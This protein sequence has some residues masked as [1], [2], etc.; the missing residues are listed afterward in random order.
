M[1][2]KQQYTKSPNHRPSAK[3]KPPESNNGSALKPRREEQLP[4][5]QN[6]LEIKKEERGIRTAQYFAKTK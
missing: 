5:I 3:I 1:T 4:T 2:K 6:M